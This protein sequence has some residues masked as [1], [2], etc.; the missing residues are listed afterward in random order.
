MHITIVDVPATIS[1][2][3]SHWDEPDPVHPMEGCFLDRETREYY[4]FFEDTVYSV[5][6]A[7]ILAI[8]VAS[9]GL[10]G[11]STYTIQVK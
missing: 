5:G 8:V 4:E 2:L 10:F 7:T 11:M 1:K 9:L 3:E 6:F